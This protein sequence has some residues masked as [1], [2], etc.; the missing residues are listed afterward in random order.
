M[1]RTTL[2]E[3]LPG[4]K[5]IFDEINNQLEPFAQSKLKELQTKYDLSN[6][7]QY[8][9]ALEEYNTA[10]T[11][12]H[13]ELLNSSQE[14]EKINESVLAAIESRFGKVKSDKL[15]EE[16][17]DKYLPSWLTN[18][19][20][21]DND[22]ARQA[23]I[24]GFVKFPKARAEERIMKNSIDYNNAMKEYKWLKYQDA[25]DSYSAN[26]SAAAGNEWAVKNQVSGN[27]TNKERI[28]FLGGQIAEIDQNI[29]ENMAKQ[30]KYQ[31][32]LNNL[33][34]PT[35]FGKD[36]SDPDLTLDEWQ[37][38][39]GDQTVQMLAAVVTGGYSTYVQE[40][41]GAAMDII[42]IHAARNAF[43]G[44][45]DSQA[46]KAFYSLPAKDTKADDNITKK[47]QQYY[48]S[49]VIE[50]G[51]ANLTPA[52][53]TGYMNAGYDLASNYFTLA[54]A[55]KFIPKSLARDLWNMQFKKFIKGGWAQVGKD[56]VSASFVEFLTETAQEGTSIV[57]VGLS[58]GYYGNKDDNL[59]RLGEA[60]AQ[61]LLSTG[62][63]TVGG[64]TA[65]TVYQEG[66]ANYRAMVDPNDVR[67]VINSM[68]KDVE[69]D[70]KS[71]KITKEKR[72]EIFTELEA[73]ESV[74]NSFKEYGEMNYDQKE[75]VVKARI[76][77]SKLNKRKK[78]LEA[79]SYTH[80]TLPTKRIV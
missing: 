71:G 51:E 53:R 15:R 23:Y 74:I 35:V 9:L 43:P 69:A 78:E 32:K 66:K 3:G 21:G 45:E 4:S 37:G 2:S 77:K 58:T 29:A 70:F 65:T 6:K 28:D 39:L 56:V 79:V 34:V 18:M 61:A 13:E 42:K 27:M 24:T 64:K 55:A 72:N 63:I 16:A 76:E 11:D 7:D 36:I 44:L 1:Y 47:G 57:N 54:K 50:N 40:G 48:M 8:G 17:E 19:F 60:G 41:G 30:D 33:R 31:E 38:M 5:K 59:K 10:I 22:Y 12:K 25:D 62:P 49:Q 68:K 75:T 14:F 67:N 80:L 46:L 73:E 20:D 26:A 52:V